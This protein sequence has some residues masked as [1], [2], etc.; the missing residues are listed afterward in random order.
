MLGAVIGDLAGSIYEYEQL[1]KVK[2]IQINKIIEDDAFFSD[3]TILTIA[4]AD[5]ILNNVGYDEKLRGYTRKFEVYRPEHDPYFPTT[6]SPNFSKWASGDLKGVSSGNGAMMRVS[7]VGYLFDSEED[8]VKHSYLATIPSHNSEQAINSARLVALI[9]YYF[10]NSMSKEDVIKKL[11]LNI[12]KP[13]ITKF[14]Y[15]CEDTVDVCLYS[16]FNSNSFEESI[17]L[18]I[19]FGGDTDTNAC[20]VGSMAEALYGINDDLKQRALDKLPREFV[21]ILESCYEKVNG[22]KEII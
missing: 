19:S 3:D 13:N 16:L 11:N 4:I 12:R 15:T 21:E 7:P 2:P 22:Y 5:A 20:I 8:V 18:A 1:K 6:F 14:N 10:R 9:I 17:K